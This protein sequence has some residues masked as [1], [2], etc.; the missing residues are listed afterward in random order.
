MY[1]KMIITYQDEYALVKLVIKNE[2]KPELVIH[3]QDEV[4]KKAYLHIL[5]S[6]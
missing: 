2:D 4:T 5:K 3:F 1:I 6:D